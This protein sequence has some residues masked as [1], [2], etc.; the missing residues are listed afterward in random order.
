MRGNIGRGNNGMNIYARLRICAAAW[1]VALI[2]PGLASAERLQGWGEIEAVSVGE[3]NRTNA[4]FFNV[5]WTQSVGGLSAGEDSWISVRETEFGVE[6]V[7]RVQTLLVSALVTRSR[8]LIVFDAS[9]GRLL[10]IR[11]AK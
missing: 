11:L 2:A 4:I 5:R 8:M 3:A 7:N 9:D 6:G 1:L 10:G